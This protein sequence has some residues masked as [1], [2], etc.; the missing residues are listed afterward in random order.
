MTVYLVYDRV[1][2]LPGN[3]GL[4]GNTRPQDS[5]LTRQFR[6]PSAGI[7]KKLFDSQ[8]SIIL[9]GHMEHTSFLN[10]VT[11]FYLLRCAISKLNL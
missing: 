8:C 3:V 7:T 10:C 5:M 1:I 9:R 2:Q 11:Y 4:F 6:D